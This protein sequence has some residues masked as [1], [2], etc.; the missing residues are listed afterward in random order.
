VHGA[1]IMLLLQS[2]VAGPAHAAL[3]FRVKIALPLVGFDAHDRLGLRFL[4]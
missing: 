2:G 3:R 1:C 4:T